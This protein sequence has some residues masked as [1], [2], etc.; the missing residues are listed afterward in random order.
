M[1]LPWPPVCFCWGTHRVFSAH[2]FLGHLPGIQSQV[3]ID[4]TRGTPLWDGEH[5]W[6]TPIQWPC[7]SIRISDTVI[8]LPVMLAG[9]Q[10]WLLCIFYLYLMHIL[11]IFYAYF[12]CMCNT[13]VYIKNNW[14]AVTDLNSS[15]QN[16][17]RQTTCGKSQTRGS[18]S[19]VLWHQPEHSKITWAPE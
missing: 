15:L 1:P 6:F 7:S 19:G 4:P 3:W 5:G 2:S 8:P 13:F 11:C 17:I 10:H 9:S 18:C 16:N 14:N 12:M